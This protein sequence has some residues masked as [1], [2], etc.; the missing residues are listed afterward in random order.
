VVLSCTASDVDID[1]GSLVIG[2]RVEFAFGKL[3]DKIVDL[4]TLIALF[5]GNRLNL[6]KVDGLCRVLEMEGELLLCI[7]PEHREETLR[8]IEADGHEGG[9]VRII[10]SGQLFLKSARLDADTKLVKIL[11]G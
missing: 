3:T 6:A 7:A 11:G 4:S 1:A 5:Q 9:T 2:T 8:R 10:D